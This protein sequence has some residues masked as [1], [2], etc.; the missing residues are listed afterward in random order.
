[1][2]EDTKSRVRRRRE[3]ARRYCR[4]ARCVGVAAGISASDMPRGAEGWRH[5]TSAIVL[6]ALAV[7]RTAS[8]SQVRPSTKQSVS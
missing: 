1:M 3:R 4:G 5:G 6:T 8:R 2:A 7:N